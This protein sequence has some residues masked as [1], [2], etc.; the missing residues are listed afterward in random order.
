VWALDPVNSP[1]LLAALRPHGHRADFEVVFVGAGWRDLV[2]ECHR[3][4]EAVFPDYELLAVKEK[5]GQL[6]FQAFPR[7]RIKAT[8]NLWTSEELSALHAI[9][10]DVRERSSAVCERCGDRGVL[11]EERGHILTLCNSCDELTPDPPG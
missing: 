10:D 1:D 2:L 8:P 5:F 3:R 6:E 7:P 9:T 4:I 11:R